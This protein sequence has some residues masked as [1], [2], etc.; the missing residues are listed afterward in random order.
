MLS[1]MTFAVDEAPSGAEAVEMVR[2]ASEAGNPYEI[3]F[4]D[5]QMPGLDG[6]ETGKRIR[7]IPGLTFV[8]HLVMVTAYGREEVLK[9][10]EANAFVNVLI[11][12]VT[13]SM[14]FDS[15]MQ[16]LGVGQVK[17]AQMQPTSSLDLKPIR[18]ARILLVEDNELNREVALGLLGD[19]Q[20]SIDVAENGEVAVGMVGKRNYDLVLMDMQMPVMD[21][22]AATR[23]IRSDARFGALPI[24]AMTANAM[25]GE[26][27]K[28]L[29]AGMN[30]HVSKPID[31]DVLFAAL[32]RWIKPRQGSSAPAPARAAEPGGA[33]SVPEIGGVDVAGGLRRVGGNT[34]LY[35][36]LLEK[37]IAKHAEAAAEISAALGNGDRKLAERTA[38]TVK[39]VAANLGISGIAA[40]AG[41]LEKNIHNGDGSA[42]AGLEEFRGQLGKQIEAIRKAL[43]EVAHHRQSPKP[44]G[45]F[46]LVAARTSIARL[47]ELLEASDGSASDAI[48]GLEQALGDRAGSAQLDS[49]RSA[50]GDFDFDGALTRLAGIAEA[51]GLGEDWA[52]R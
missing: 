12:P 2:R 49:L 22:L 44:A 39:G 40:D 19:A 11:K 24:V 1:S 7:T 41:E 31:P 35:L 9:Q 42:P 23:A 33:L 16:A 36:D 38:H 48:A 50:I 34:R 10:A 27:E 8:P 4:L 13:P 15:V 20:L 3:V 6:I 18:G 32:L 52:K 30:D 25:A 14:L 28:C 26:R 45:S 17:A 43:G 37:F 51:C 46:D 5:W 21:G 47:R 29:Q